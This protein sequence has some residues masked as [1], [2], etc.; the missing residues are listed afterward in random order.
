MHSHKLRI[1]MNTPSIEYNNSY[2]Q[3]DINILNLAQMDFLYVTLV[4]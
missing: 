4:A 1:S 3:V 2:N